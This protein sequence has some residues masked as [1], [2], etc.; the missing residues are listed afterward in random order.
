MGGAVA[1]ALAAEGL[2]TAA[3]LR[4]HGAAALQRR[5]GLRPAVA[6]AL[7]AWAHGVDAR[8]VEERGP[9]KAIQAR[10]RRRGGCQGLGRRHGGGGGGE[11]WS[12]CL[13]GFC[14]EAWLCQGWMDG[15]NRGRGTGWRRRA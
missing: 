5:F 15:S 3:D 4:G 13:W 11:V 6:E 9:P 14:V 10:R 12:S 1:E 2:H 8:P 7:A